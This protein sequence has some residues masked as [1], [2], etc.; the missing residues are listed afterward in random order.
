ME[1]QKC[2][3]RP[4]RVVKV[5][6]RNVIKVSAPGLFSTTDDP[7]LLPPVYPF[8]ELTKNSFSELVVGDEVWL[9]SVQDNPQELFWIRK[10][11]Y[12]MGMEDKAVNG[13]LEI[14]SRRESGASWAEIFFSDGTGWIIRNDSSYIGINKDGDITLSVLGNHKTIEINKDGI[15]LGS[16]GTSAEPAV[17]GDKLTDVLDYISLI[18]DTLADVAGQNPYTVPIALIINTM[19]PILD[20]KIEKIC[21]SYVTLD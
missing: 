9:L 20:K 14:L 13:N 17:L 1:L 12:D 5:L 10:P 11:D 7:D 2:I 4:A 8:L 16:K 21:S 3:L 6:D 19:K 18:F 15:S